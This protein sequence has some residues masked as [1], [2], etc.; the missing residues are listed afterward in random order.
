MVVYRKNSCAGKEHINI[1]ISCSPIISS[2]NIVQYWKGRL[3]RIY[4]KNLEIKE[5]ILWGI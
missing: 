2:C 4:K 3:S 1:L 5:K